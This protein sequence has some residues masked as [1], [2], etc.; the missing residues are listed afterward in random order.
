VTSATPSVSV[1]VPNW[2]GLDFLDRC[3]RSL[4]GQTLSPSEVIVVDN[5][6]TDG[7][8]EFVERAYPEVVVLAQSR[9]LGFAGGVNAGIKAASGDL[10]ALLNNDAEADPDWLRHL[11]GRMAAV[12]PE[13]GVVTSKIVAFDTGTI[14]STGDF[15]DTYG[16]AVPRGR[17]EPDDGRYDQAVDVFSGS[18][19]ASLY[20][21]AMLDRVG[22]FDEDFFAYYEDVDL[23]FRA[24]LAGYRAVFEP[25]AVVRHHIGGTSGKLPGFGRYHILK[26]VWFLYFKNMPAWVFWSQLPRFLRGQEQWARAAIR[27]GESRIVVRAYATMLRQ[28]PRTLRKRHAIQRAR[29]VSPGSIRRALYRPARPSRA[30]AGG[31]RDTAS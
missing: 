7:S 26:N 6:S 12:G 13:V 19:G 31:H 23:G 5:G 3:L 10:V 28:L 4:R 11:V 2:N 18:G 15:V 24:R 21:R 16:R 20:R 8:T 22:L 27:R 1:I 14:D 30:T 9:N 25:A 17:G 29:A